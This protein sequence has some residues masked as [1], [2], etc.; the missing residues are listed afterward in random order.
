M[1]RI[2]GPAAHARTDTMRAQALAPRTAAEALAQREDDHQR[3]ADDGGLTP[4][5]EGAGPDVR[6]A[7]SVVTRYA[8]VTL[9]SVAALGFALGRRAGRR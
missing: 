9:G 4:D 5:P 8:W 6:T 3:W 2:P 7:A 1:A